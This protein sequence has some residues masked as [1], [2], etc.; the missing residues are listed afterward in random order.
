VS[1]ARWTTCASN[2]LRPRS[3]PAGGTDGGSARRMMSLRNRNCS[4]RPLKCRV[5]AAASRK[6]GCTLI[7]GK[8]QTCKVGA[9]GS[10]R[11]ANRLFVTVWEWEKDA[12]KLLI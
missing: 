10:E 3:E 6:W 4:F 11:G 9:V 12:Y 5:F 7:V 2:T 8:V 1:C